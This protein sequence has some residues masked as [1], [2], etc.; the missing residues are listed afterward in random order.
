MI[1]WHPTAPLTWD[2][3]CRP[4][5]SKVSST[6]TRP[7]QNS[8]AS[9]YSRSLDRTAIVIKSDLRVVASTKIDFD[10]D[11]GGTYPICKGVLANKQLG[12]VYAPVAMWFQS[13]DLVLSRL[14][15]TG[16]DL[17]KVR[18]LSGSCQQH[19]SVWW[20]PE[21]ESRLGAL[22]ENM[23]LPEQ[24]EGALS[25]PFAPNWQD[26]STQA[27]CDELDQLFGSAKKL[28]NVTG[29]AAHHVC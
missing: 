25:H 19:G 6:H 13:I 3:T 4:S 16:I 2:L 20:G 18:G 7:P 22:D 14:V 21:A 11:M 12:E 10:T 26:H 17:S 5:N 9:K 15:E 28:A 1:I 27:E 8:S 24:L 29:S 23:T